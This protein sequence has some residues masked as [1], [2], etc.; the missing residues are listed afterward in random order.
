MIIVLKIT[1]FLIQV[2]LTNPFYSHGI[3]IPC[4]SAILLLMIFNNHWDSVT[5]DIKSCGLILLFVGILVFLT[6]LF[7]DMY[8]IMAFSIPLGVYGFC[9]MLLHE[10]SKDFL[11]PVLFLF[12]MIPLSQVEYLAVYLSFFSSSI[13]TMI[14]TLIGMTVTQSGATIILPGSTLL[15]GAPCSGLSSLLSFVAIGC[16]VLY[17]LPFIWWEKIAFFLLLPLLAIISNIIRLLLII[18]ISYRSGVE[19]ALMFFHSMYGSLIYLIVFTIYC[20]FLVWK[21]RTFRRI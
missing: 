9:S 10:Y 16:V 12:F 20:L 17:L 19:E 15:V 8:I 5:L 7:T 2:W 3:L 1:P 4:I 21:A 14:A 13:A 18:L 11:F 6:G